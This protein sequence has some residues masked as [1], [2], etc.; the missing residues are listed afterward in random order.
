MF[1]IYANLL[2][3]DLNKKYTNLYVVGIVKDKKE[4]RIKIKLININNALH[5]RAPK[6]FRT[7]QGPFLSK[8]KANADGAGQKNNSAGTKTF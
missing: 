2:A 1:P 8:L 3:S 5:N 7:N 6:Y 4:H